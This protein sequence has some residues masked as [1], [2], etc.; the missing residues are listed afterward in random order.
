MKL[1]NALHIFTDLKN[2]SVKKS[3][4]KIYNQFITLIT[5]LIK[6]DLSRNELQSIE[7]ELDGL[8]LNTIQTK[9]LRFYRKGLIKFETFLKEKLTLVST[10]H[11]TKLYGGLGMSFGILFGIVILSNF[12]QSLSISLGIL[13]GMVVGASIGRSM[14][15]KAKIEGR[16]L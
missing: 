10:Q 12:E 15:A 9:K 16:V 13:I 2:Q 3:E 1:E 5:G 4:I 8:E 14:D 6:R 11:Y 7:L